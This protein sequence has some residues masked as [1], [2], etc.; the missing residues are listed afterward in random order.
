MSGSNSKGKALLNPF[1]IG[2]LFFSTLP[3]HSLLVL[4]GM[5][6]DTDEFVG[7]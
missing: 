3:C 7:V 4:L 6:T 2:V 5:L 1:A